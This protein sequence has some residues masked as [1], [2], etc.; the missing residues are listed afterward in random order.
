M[1]QITTYAVTKLHLSKTRFRVGSRQTYT[2]S[3]TE[4]VSYHVT[5]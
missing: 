5:M 2:N 3:R 4:K 1:F